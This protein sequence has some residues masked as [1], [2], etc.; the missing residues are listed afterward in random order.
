M[1]LIDSFVEMCIQKEYVSQ[2]EAQWLR[3]AL[4][5]R[6]T[7]TIVFVPLIIIGLLIAEPASLLTFLITFFLL[8]T[9]TNGFHARSIGRCLLYSILG[10]VFFLRLL[11][12]IWNEIIAFITLTMS[13]MLIWAY[14]P[15]NHPNM[16][17]SSEEVVACA[18]SAKLRLSILFFALCVFYIW[19]QAQLAEGIRMGIILTASTLVMARGLKKCKKG[20]ELI[21]FLF[22]RRSF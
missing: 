10:E 14:A 16:D 22:A 8:R 20:K 15:Y 5:K 19:R 7:S 18:R 4:E 13:I 9:R 12:T 3:Y 6:I 1:K 17:L 2:D 11:P 21:L